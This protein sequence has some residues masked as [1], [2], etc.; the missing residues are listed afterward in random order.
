V[1]F[2]DAVVRAGHNPWIVKV[3]N[4]G[5]Q[6]PDC[7]ARF[8]RSHREIAAHLD[9]TD[10]PVTYLAPT[11]YME[12][13]LWAVDAIRDE[14]TVP[15][16]AGDARISFVA[17]KDVAAVAANVL[18]EATPVPGIRSLTGP[19][20]LGYGDVASRIS[21][22][23]ATTVDYTDQTPKQARQSLLGAGMSPWEA[24]GQ[25]EVFD[26]ARNGGYDFVTEE[27]RAVTGRDATPIQSWLEDERAAFLRPAGA[28]PP[29]P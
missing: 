8:M 18:A 5:F 2:V 20:S 4:D 1:R 15:A 12:D 26:W 19:E 3:A 27:V 16:P 17:A 9:A 22:V 14:G 25:L 23:F 11:M 24:D 13:L 10:L 29:G 6:E 21:A 7:E 28:P